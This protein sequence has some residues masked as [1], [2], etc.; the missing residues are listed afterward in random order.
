VALRG[1]GEVGSCSVLTA[2]VGDV[3]T[4]SAAAAAAAAAAAH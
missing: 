3:V 1:R 4:A 2:P